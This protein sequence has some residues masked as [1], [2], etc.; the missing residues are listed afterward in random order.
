MDMST[1][2]AID[3]HECFGRLAR[4]IDSEGQRLR[5]DV[6]LGVPSVPRV[7]LDAS[8]SKSSDLRTR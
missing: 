6:L 5:S 1:K 3:L 7:D 4:G 2:K 8:I